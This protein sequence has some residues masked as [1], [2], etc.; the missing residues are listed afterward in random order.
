MY[1]FYYPIAYSFANAFKLH[2]GVCMKREP[3][4]NF[5][6]SYFFVHF[7]EVK[8]ADPRT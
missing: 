4:S 6:D 8:T 1:S 3:I 2:R 5:L 7:L